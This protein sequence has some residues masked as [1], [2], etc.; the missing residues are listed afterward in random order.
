MSER[1]N[2]LRKA[3][4][5]HRV[6]TRDQDPRLARDELDRAATARGYSIVETIEETG[7]GAR[8]DRPGL[9]R[10]MDLANLGKV[11][12]VLVWKLD[13]AGRS[14]IDVLT[15]INSLKSAGVTFIA[16]SQGLEM[17]PKGDAVSTLMLNVLASVAEFERELI[18]ERTALG[19]DRAR[20]KG[21]RL[22]RPPAMTPYGE[23]R[24]LRLRE[25]GRSWSETAREMECSV[26]A[27]RR[28]VERAKRRLVGKGPSSERD[29]LPMTTT[30]EVGM[31]ETFVSDNDTQSD[32]GE[33]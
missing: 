29:E 7:S 25:H 1:G 13:R 17:S 32:R 21:V 30:R 26:S 28:A 11:D 2:E 22:G 19:L 6:S 3:V 27:A 14:V 4:I 24:A 10:V 33:R 23:D 20:K 31:S 15:T 9:Q 12:A 16:T 18:A 8:N 5:Y